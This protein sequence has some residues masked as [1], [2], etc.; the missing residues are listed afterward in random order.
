MAPKTFRFAPSPNGALHLGHAYSALLNAQLSR[1]T[2]GRLLLR[3]EDIDRA[4][5]PQALC[6][7]AID[8]LAW[9]GLFWDALPVWQ[10]QRF[11]AYQAAQITLRDAGLTYPCFCSRSDIFHATSGMRDWPRDPDGSPKYP[12]TCRAL[13]PDVVAQKIAAGDAHAWRL[14]M[15]LAVACTGPLTWREWS[16]SDVAVA[17]HR[18]RSSTT[19]IAAEPNAW[20]DV[21]LVRKDIGTSY[22]LAVV[23]DDA[24]Q[25]VTHVVRGRDLY[26]ATSVHRVLQAL[27]GLPAPKYR[28]HA[29]L[30]D[31]GGEKLAKSKSAPSLREFRTAG[32]TAAEVR[33]RLGFG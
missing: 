23:V 17:K 27:L 4:R 28:H 26:A 21:I 12:G 5:C 33:A 22:H 13:S 7:A 10:S 15:G 2:G 19:E 14:D 11:P 8:D 31:S 16:E 6:D 20:G 3:L 9:L 1:E 30:A 24:W 25:G 18:Q 32:G 29:L